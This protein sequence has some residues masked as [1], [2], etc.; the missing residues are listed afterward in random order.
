[1]LNI[2]E[3]K[4]YALINLVNYILFFIFYKFICKAKLITI[5]MQEVV[6]YFY[7]FF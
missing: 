2:N 3:Y 6:N 5:K 1:M 7:H 4:L